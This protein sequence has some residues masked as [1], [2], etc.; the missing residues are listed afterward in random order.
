M[1]V[2]LTTLVPVEGNPHGAGESDEDEKGIERM[3]K[4][5]EGS[6]GDDSCYYKKIINQTTVFNS[7]LT[8][9]RSLPVF[10]RFVLGSRLQIL[11]YQV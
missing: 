8:E 10:K 1:I 9:N 2:A 6:I 4:S 5:T 3:T 7:I 11:L